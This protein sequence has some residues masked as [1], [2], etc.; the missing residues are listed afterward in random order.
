MAL[1]L[2][3]VISG[4]AGRTAAPASSGALSALP[5]SDIVVTIDTQRALSEA[6][7]SILSDNPGMLAKINNK[8]EAFNKET[9]IDLRTFDSLAV[10]LRFRSQSTKDFD[11][12]VVSRGHFNASEVI[13]AGFASAKNKNDFQRAEEQYEGKTIF[14]LKPV[15]HEAGKQ[16]GDEGAKSNAVAVSKKSETKIGADSS[17]EQAAQYNV[18]VRTTSEQP[19]AVVALDANTIAVG[20]LKSVRATIDA[21]M[22]RERV[23]DELVRMATQNSSALVGFS[24]R[25]PAAVKEK[26]LAGKG[27]P[28]TKYIAS[29]REFYGSFG[30][31]GTETESLVAV[32]TENAA[33]AND[34]GKALS[35][36][37]MLSSLGM[38]RFGAN[39]SNIIAE[40]VKGLTITTQDNE[41]QLKLNMNQKVFAPFVRGF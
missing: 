20:D 10:G 21:S 17:Q 6:L 18:K 3:T 13:D 35:A 1:T 11:A 2:A 40:A 29:I 32:R 39:E 9:G 23:D 30:L 37:K 41:V 7:P 5:A 16:E 24:G 36:L 28:E 26:M 8:I 15:K 33:Q 4:F 14:V 31:L 27:G 34:L 25:I 12:V 38:P 19:M 22:G